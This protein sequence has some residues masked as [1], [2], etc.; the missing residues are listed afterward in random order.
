LSNF[1]AWRTAYAAAL[2]TERGQ[3]ANLIGVHTE[4]SLVERSADREILPMAE[5]LG[6]GAVLYSLLG[7]SLLTGKYRRSDRGR[8]TT[9]GGA[10][11]REDTTQ[12]SAVLDA[13]L[14]IATEMG[15]SPA[16]IAM[17]W[18]FEHARRLSTTVIPMIGPRSC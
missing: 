8:L 9:L 17:A 1:P 12:K 2:P 14:Q 6:L 4:Y 3:S 18:L 7:G 13:V 15:C 5:A 16:Q 11:Q 10:I